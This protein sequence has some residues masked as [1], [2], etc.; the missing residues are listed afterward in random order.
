MV[1]NIPSSGAS[2]N[3]TSWQGYTDTKM[4]YRTV[5]HKGISTDVKDEIKNAI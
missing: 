4:K 3:P 5:Y 2:E 1:E